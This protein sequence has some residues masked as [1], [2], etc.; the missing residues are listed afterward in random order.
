MSKIRRK[1]NFVLAFL[2]LIKLGNGVT[3]TFIKENNSTKISTFQ[4]VKTVP[5]VINESMCVMLVQKAN[6]DQVEKLNFEYAF[7]FVI[8]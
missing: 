1:Y 8:N 6:L 4:T 3:Q 7:Y 5:D 2:L